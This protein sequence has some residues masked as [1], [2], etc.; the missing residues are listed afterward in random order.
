MLPKAPPVPSV[1]ENNCCRLVGDVDNAFSNVALSSV[2]LPVPSKP[3]PTPI[4][5]VKLLPTNGDMIA[6]RID[7]L[8]PCSSGSREMLA[9]PLCAAEAWSLVNLMTS[10]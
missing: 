5:C 9:R 4:N 10:L 7:S 8:K 2:M 1:P 3:M 6:P